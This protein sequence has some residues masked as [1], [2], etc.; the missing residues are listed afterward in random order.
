MKLI[1]FRRVQMLWFHTCIIF[2]RALDLERPMP[3]F[4]ATIAQDK[5]KILWYCAWR[6]CIGLHKSISLNFLIAGH[7]K[8]AP[9][10]CFGFPK[11]AFKRHAVSS[12]EEFETVVKESACVN[13]AQLIG[14][15]DGTSFVSVGE[16]QQYLSP[17]F[18]PFLE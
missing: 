3:N 18:K 17:Y 2:L 5:T 9:D 15:E 7:M 16:W 1:S 14:K 13:Q 10:R 6:V 4:T 12:L 8:F 11:R